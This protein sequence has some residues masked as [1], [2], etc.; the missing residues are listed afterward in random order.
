MKNKKHNAHVKAWKHHKEAIE[1]MLWVSQM[2]GLPENLTNSQMH[3]V[4]RKVKKSK[5]LQ[6]LADVNII[7]N[8][9]M[10]QLY[11]HKQRET[12]H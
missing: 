5:R 8:Q 4:G 12:I 7:A 6:R 10:F 11:G 3:V 1:V 9:T 2:M